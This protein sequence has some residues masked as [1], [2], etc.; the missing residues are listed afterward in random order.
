MRPE[1]IETLLDV[2]GGRLRSFM[3]GSGPTLVLLA[4]G[5]GDAARTEAL[6]N[7][8]ADRYTVL[9][10]DRR[11]LSESTT[12][13]P[14]GTLA[15]HADDVSRLL[16]HR[17]A[18]PVHVYGTSFGAL[19]A[20][21]L[22]AADPGRL[23]VVI[24]HEP[25]VTQL[26]P[27]AQRRAAAAQL[28]DVQNRFLT[29]GVGAALQRFAEVLA[30]DPT[31]REP[32]VEVPAAGPQQLANAAYFLTHDL[33]LVRRHA[34]DLA[35]LTAS[36]ANL[37]T[38]VGQTSGDIW[39]HR[40]GRLLADELAVPVQT[41]PGGHSGYAL[42]PRAT[43][44]RIHQVLQDIGGHRPRRRTTPAGPPRSTGRSAAGRG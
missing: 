21:E 3:R 24:A 35:A 31:D 18:G 39:P 5:H 22:A 44:D 7:H 20:L 41:F 1:A 15:T 37:V 16:G 34:V 10:Y 42:R 23:D 6:A 32:G 28:Q 38:A 17:T 25:P 19:I 8:L 4:G 13:A 26:L 36:R 14:A 40:C 2:P 27:P 9:T 33:P 11:G 29:G 30:T 43:A 12:S